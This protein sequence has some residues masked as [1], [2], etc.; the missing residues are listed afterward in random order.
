MNMTE[1]TYG[2]V[3]DFIR[4]IFRRGFG[5]TRLANMALKICVLNNVFEDAQEFKTDR[6]KLDANTFQTALKVMTERLG[7]REFH[8]RSIELLLYLVMPDAAAHNIAKDILMEVFQNALTKAEA[9]SEY[10]YSHITHLAHLFFRHRIL[11][12][13]LIITALKVCILMGRTEDAQAIKVQYGAFIDDTDQIPDD[14][15]YFTEGKRHKPEVN[16]QSEYNRHEIQI[17]AEKIGYR[18]TT[19]LA[20]DYRNMARIL[21]P[22]KQQ[23]SGELM[24]EL[25]RLFGK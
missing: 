14:D 25:N 18:V 24:K 11:N 8:L 20:K 4:V 3:K 1:S 23:S 17:F 5:D 9:M 19:D 2:K 10:S 15:S 6:T 7:T 12:S 13:D 16:H 21:H 22:D